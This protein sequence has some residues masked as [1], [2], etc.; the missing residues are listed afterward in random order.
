[1]IES[2]P[3]ALFRKW[4]REAIEEKVNKPEAMA[5]ATAG[6]DGKPSVRIVLL[7]NLSEEGFRFFTNYESQKS[8]EIE[9]NP[10]VSLMFHWPEL[11][12]EIRIEG[13]AVKTAEEISDDYFKT[14][15]IESRI[16]AIISPQSKPVP[17]RDYLDKLWNEKYAELKEKEFHRPA[18]WGG[19]NVVPEKI[20]FWQAASNRLND[21]VLYTKKD[22]Q[23]KITRLAP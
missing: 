15:P 2:D 17:G 1:M 6:K 5:V 8:R 9:E 10:N 12:R 11:E 16:S 19:Y 22:N 14:R 21:R 18:Y 4:F 3:L 7:K 20:E 23:W 13:Y